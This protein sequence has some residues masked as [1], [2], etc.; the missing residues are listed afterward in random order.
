MAKQFAP[1]IPEGITLL[2][3]K[4]EQHIDEQYQERLYEGVPVVLIR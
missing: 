2:V 1:T 4:K 3:C